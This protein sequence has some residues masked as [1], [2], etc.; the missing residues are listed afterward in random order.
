[1]GANPKVVRALTLT[2]QYPNTLTLVLTLTLT[3]T[4]YNYQLPYI[5]ESSAPCVL[6]LLLLLINN[7]SV[8]FF[9]STE[10]TYSLKF[11]I[12]L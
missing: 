2:P 6:L 9:H 11:K 7:F 3:L 8:T 12:T 10:L 4:P 5:D 1:M